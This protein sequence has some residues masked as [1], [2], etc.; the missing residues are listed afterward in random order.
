V[1]PDPPATLI[2][3]LRAAG[4]VFAEE[5]AALLSAAATSPADL[6]RL[7]DLRVFGL[8]LEHV[9]GWVQFAGRRFVVEPGV[10]V[11]R[12]RTELLVRCA[13]ASLAR[14]VETTVVEMCCGCAA[15]AATIA[16]EVPGASVYATDIDPAAVR[17]AR[18]NLLPLGGQVFQ[19]DLYEPLPHVLQESIDLVIANAPYVPTDGIELMP[20]EAREHE[21]RTAL[22]GGPDGLDILRRVVL[23]AAP[24][25]APEATMIVEIS[26]SQV[27]A[28]ISVA[29]AVGKKCRHVTDDDIGGSV[30]LIQRVRS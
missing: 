28:L 19:G 17:C 12:R 13:M 9:L 27:A 15:I 7:V 6:Q 20:P 14:K 4:C 3:R 23:E 5:E 25:L 8:P 18:Q 22:D 2:A 21:P 16:D 10:F 26:P 30:L 11:P 29:E 24:W 1:S